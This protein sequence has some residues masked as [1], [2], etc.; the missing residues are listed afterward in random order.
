M[1][2]A[3]LL[4]Q[5]LAAAY[6]II[7][8]LF[9]LITILELAQNAKYLVYFVNDGKQLYESISCTRAQGLSYREHQ[10]EHSRTYSVA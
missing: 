2:D 9:L 4:L 10:H 3:K 1:H 5:I 7:R 6:I 8:S